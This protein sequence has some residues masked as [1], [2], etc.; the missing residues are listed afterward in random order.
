MHVSTP[1]QRSTYSEH[2]LPLTALKIDKVPN[3]QKPKIERPCVLVATVSGQRR[4][5]CSSIFRR[6][7]RRISHAVKL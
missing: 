5:S 2:S 7:N 1:K 6:F 4:Y 3:G